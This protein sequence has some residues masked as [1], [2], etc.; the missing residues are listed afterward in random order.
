M[1]TMAAIMFASMLA[2]IAVV[3]LEPGGQHYH[4]HDLVAFHGTHALLAKLD[5]VARG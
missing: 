5:R 4:R 1:R 2:A 3:A